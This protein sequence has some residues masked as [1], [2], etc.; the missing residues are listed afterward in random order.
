MRPGGVGGT[1]WALAAV[2]WMALACA[3]SAGHA[4][5][6][7]L[8]EPPPESPEDADYTV[9]LA[10]S[11]DGGEVE[12]AL[13]MT[14]RAGST[15]R[16]RRRLRLSGD[17]L[18]AAVRDDESLGGGSL[19]SRT[20]G[21]AFGVG[22]MAPRWGLGL[23]LGSSDE[24]WRSD[25]L[26]RG[27]RA[28]FRGR[29]GEGGWVRRDGRGSYELVAGRFAKRTLAAASLG[30]GG[31]GFG[32]LAAR[33]GGAQGS[34]F[35]Q[36]PRGGAE[37]AF[38]RDGRWRAEVAL[39]RRAGPWRAGVRVRGGVEAYAS[40]AE[41]RRSGPARALATHATWRRDALRVRTVAALWRFAPGVD[42]ARAMIE[43]RLVA[44]GR[45]RL[46]AGI[47]EQHGV[48]RAPATVPA[49]PPGMRQGAWIEW[50]GTGE[51]FALRVR[52]EVWGRAARARD[53]VRTVTAAGVDVRLGFGARLRVV[54]TAFETRRGEHVYLPEAES[55][56]LVLRAVRGSGNR[57]RVETG[58]PVGRG[59]L[60]GSLVIANGTG[61]SQARWTLEWAR[62]V[63]MRRSR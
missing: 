7:A 46:S 42:G 2:V 18:E 22:R 40:L 21:G 57:T 36:R 10:D 20:H 60:R 19:E 32:A 16:R 17:S 35:L 39:D 49:D 34:V 47:E 9:E 55:D 33:T 12:V 53:A 4:D 43:A 11:L 8:H 27:A 24:P 62:R 23:V 6:D 30:V 51:P 26:D 28:P 58:V 38:D 3:A 56:R 63:R 31:L 15:P 37:L 44:G 5:E 61:A 45:G 50:R 59:E 48:R 29:S 25:P 13:G 41:P 52:H 14:G 54:H 1:G